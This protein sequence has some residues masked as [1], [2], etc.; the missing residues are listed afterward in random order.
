MKYSIISK[1]YGQEKRGAFTS[2]LRLQ[3]KF[4]CINAYGVHQLDDLAEIRK[5]STRLLFFTQAPQM[6]RKLYSITKQKPS[7]LVFIRKKYNPKLWINPTSNG[8][9]YWKGA[10]SIKWF[11][12]FIANLDKSLIN[13]QTETITIGYYVRPNL[14]PDSIKAFTEFVNSL[15]FDVKI[16]TMGIN[17]LKFNKFKHVIDHVHTYDNIEFFNNV[18]HYYHYKSR[19]FEDP[20]PNTLYESVNL[21]KQIIIAGEDREWS[22]GVDDIESCIKCHKELTSKIYDNSN[23]ILNADNFTNFYNKLFENNFDYLINKNKYK[24]FRD[25]C[26]NE[27]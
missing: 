13:P 26:E 15:K 4:E 7:D 8:F 9:S 18:T 6:N 19:V 14:T 25:W 10:P 20:L 23:T 24:T 11:F 21:N 2:A 12:P 22:D 5:K 27:L 3:E 16:Y 17:A 1:M